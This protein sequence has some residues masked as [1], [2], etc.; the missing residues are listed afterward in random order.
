MERAVRVHKTPCY[1][2]KHFLGAKKGRCTAFPAEI[3]QLIWSGS[4][5]HTE[6][7]PGDRGIRFEPNIASE[8]LTISEV[9]KALKVNPKTIY[10]AVWSKKIPAY[11]IGKA[12]RIAKKD[13]EVF[14]K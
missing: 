6:P 11:K 8:F 1:R 4:S 13:L 10:R 9:A 7:F 12:V 2:C 3:P 14:K 5:Q